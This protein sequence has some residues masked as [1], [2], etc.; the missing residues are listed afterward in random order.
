MWLP[1]E[2]VRGLNYLQT[3]PSK[4]SQQLSSMFRHSSPQFATNSPTKYYCISYQRG[5]KKPLKLWVPAETPVK[6]FGSGEKKSPLAPM[7]NREEEGSFRVQLFQYIS[8]N[9]WKSASQLWSLL[10]VSRTPASDTAPESYQ[11]KHLVALIRSLCP[12]PAPHT[13]AQAIREDHFQQQLYI[14][15]IPKPCQTLSCCLSVPFQLIHPAPVKSVISHGHWRQSPLVSNLKVNQLL[16]P[17][18]LSRSPWHPTQSLETSIHQLS[19]QITECLP[20]GHRG[21]A[22][23]WDL[24]EFAIICYLHIKWHH[25][26]LETVWFCFPNGSLCKSKLEFFHQTILFN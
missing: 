21:K 13:L 4:P 11:G 8:P 2:F 3:C 26:T 15:Q 19:R 6:N 17:S 12:M 10:E 23:S 14:G 5:R 22:V 20:S 16:T 24:L 18:S 25:K 7:G 9:K 1:E